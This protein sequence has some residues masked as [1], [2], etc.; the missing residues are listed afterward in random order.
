MSK[1]VS[2]NSIN[3]AEDQIEERRQ[4]I[5]YD[6]REF[7]I[8]IIVNKYLEKDDDDLS[9][10]YVPEYQREFVWDITRQSKLIESIVLGLPIPLLF[11]AEI[12]ETGRL[13]IVDG[14]QRVRTLAAFIKN[15]L[16]LTNLRTL[17]YLNGFYFNDFPPSRQRKFKN[18][19]IRMIVL[20]DKA[21]E[22]VR[23]DMFDRINTSSLDLT[24]METRKGVYR[25]DFIDFVFECSKTKILVDLCPIYKYF[26]NR[27]E[28]AELVL[29]F[30]AFSETYPEFI[31]ADVKNHNDLERT[32]VARFLDEY[33]L[34]KN[35]TFTN[36]EKKQKI[37]DFKRML[38]FIV[39]TFP[40]GFKKYQ[41]SDATS[42]PYFEAISVGSYLALKQKPDLVVK[43]LWKSSDKNNQSN[44]FRIPIG[45]YQTHKPENMRQRIDYVKEKLL[46]HSL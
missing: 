26:Q 23:N 20:S 19:P 7:T 22:R 38:D 42:R 10:I 28:E 3:M 14:S 31:I 13:E 4:E 2:P 1:A 41:D 45:R 11:V 40:S 16:R 27:N 39:K 12:K 17:N 9:E 36:E 29:R 32:G 34:W 43:N 46:N 44:S 21:D 15:Q 30:F 8:E 33:I 18:T 35:R 5:D 24:P 6:T 37:Y 25:G